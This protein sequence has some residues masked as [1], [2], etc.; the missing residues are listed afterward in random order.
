MKI[1]SIILFSFLLFSIQP[2]KAATYDI[3]GGTFHAPFWS[4]EPTILTSSEQLIDGEY[5]GRFDD[6]IFCGCPTTTYFSPTGVDGVNHPAPTID[7]DA[8]IADMTSF[9]AFWNGTESN[10]GG[11]AVINSNLDGTYTL[12]WD[13]LLVGGPFDGF[14]IYWTMDIR[15]VPLPAAFLANGFGSGWTI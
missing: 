7:L 11:M 14:T 4:A 5:S 3:L 9:Y 1:K 12:S 10:Q 6:F 2:V 8:G 13:K 15:P